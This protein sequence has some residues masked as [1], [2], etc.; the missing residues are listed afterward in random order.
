MG[1]G[2]HEG[3]IVKWHFKEGDAVKADQTIVEVETDKAVVE[4]PAPASGTILKINYQVGQVVK[5]GE[6]LVVI[7]AP[8]EKVS[9]AAPAPSQAEEKPSV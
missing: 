5:V 7:G 4:L 8:G 1:E 9:A 6:V 2:I 3:T